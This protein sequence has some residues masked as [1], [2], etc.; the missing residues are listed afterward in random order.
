V[1]NLVVT[2]QDLINLQLTNGSNV[3]N[4][5]IIKDLILEHDTSSMLDG[6]RYYLNQNDILDRKMYYIVDGVKTEDTEKV[7]NKIPHNWHKLLV[8]Q[9]VNYLLGKPPVIQA[10]DE[11]YT[12]R[13][14]DILDEDFDD[15][16]QELGKGASNK[17]VEYLH[18]YINTKGD[19]DYIIVPAEEVIPIYETSKQK[20]LTAAIRYYLVTVN[21]TDKIRAEWWTDKDVT[22]YIENDIGEFELDSTVE[23]NPQSHFYY[24]DKGYGWSKVPFI[25][26]RNNEEM[27][28]DLTFYKELI[29]IYDKNISDFANNLEELQELIYVLKGYDGSDLSEFIQNLRYYKAIKVSEDGGVDTLKL[30]IPVEAKR[31]M[32]DRLEENIFLFGQGVNVKT[33]K[34]GNSPSG[35]ALKFLYMLLDLKANHMERK[36]RKA[37]KQFVW[38]VTEYINIKDRKTYDYRTVQFT[39]TKS[40]LVNDLETA[41]IAQISKGII[42]DDTIVAN[43][44]WVEDAQEE[45]EK[46]KEQREN[47]IDLDLIEGVMNGTNIQEE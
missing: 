10:D 9:K 1:I 13:L 18:P 28:S 6:V 15:I 42:S 7:N 24:N 12:Q 23:E 17:G 22:Y 29:D 2:E 46:V 11:K 3:T 41:Q 45:L 39:F 31:E 40:M 44:P 4:E 35:I 16:L 30:E 33:D 20:K 25:A 43:H 32:L 27:V 5:K 14:N 38:F 8:D 47:M 26:F 34:F 19:F 36:F 37:L 21:G